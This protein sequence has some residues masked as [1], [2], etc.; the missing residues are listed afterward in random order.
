MSWPFWDKHL[1]GFTSETVIIVRLILTG[2]GFK[3]AQRAPWRPLHRRDTLDEPYALS[4]DPGPF[5]L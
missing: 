3:Q 5:Q 1:Y 4:F 2:L